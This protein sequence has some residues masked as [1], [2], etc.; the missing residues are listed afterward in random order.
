ML[1]PF[2]K[3]HKAIEALN[4]SP[5]LVNNL[6][7]GFWTNG[8]PLQPFAAVCNG[9][10]FKLSWLLMVVIVFN[11][12]YNTA[13]RPT[14]TPPMTIMDKPLKNKRSLSLLFFRYLH[15]LLDISHSLIK[16][17]PAAAT[18]CSAPPGFGKKWKLCE[19]L[20]LPHF[21]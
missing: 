12:N 19:K 18:V 16:E 21:C 10:R 7:L 6:F 9:F 13:N 4:A 2:V 17:L 3:L 5:A 1:E 20:C 8:L 11:G 15:L 14:I